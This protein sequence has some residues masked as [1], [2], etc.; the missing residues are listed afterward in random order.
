M[1]KLWRGYKNFEN[2]G[3]PVFSAQE[4]RSK[5]KQPGL[6]AHMPN[7][8]GQSFSVKTTLSVITNVCP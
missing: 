3:I 7:S 4:I 2:C 1:N 5:G 6:L 8:S